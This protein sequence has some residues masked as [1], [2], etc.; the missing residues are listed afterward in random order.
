[1]KLDPAMVLSAILQNIVL[2]PIP[3]L[4]IYKWLDW[5]CKT[6]YLSFPR[7]YENSRINKHQGRLPS[8]AIR[9][10]FIEGM[11]FSKMATYVLPQK[12]LFLDAGKIS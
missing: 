8:S 4:H 11:F 7:W 10:K 3:F 5:S 2:E 9:H 6:Q 12:V 1:M